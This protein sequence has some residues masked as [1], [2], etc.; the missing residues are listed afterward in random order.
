MRYAVDPLHSRHGRYKLGH[1]KSHRHHEE[2]RDEP[3]PHHPNMTTWP[4]LTS[5]I[6][7]Y[8]KNTPERRG[9]ENVEVTEATTPM[10][11]TE[12]AIVSS[13][14]MSSSSDHE[15]AV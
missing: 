10:I 5:C 13:I 11:E 2:T 12:K 14:L 4:P 1:G 6:T 15:F 7:T 8:G 3:S 9:N